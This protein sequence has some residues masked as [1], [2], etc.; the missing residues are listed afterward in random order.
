[1]QTIALLTVVFLPA[2]TVA[3]IFSMSPFFTAEPGG[4]MAV[5]AEFWIYWAVCI[6]LTLL[7]VLI[8]YLWFRRTRE[9]YRVEDKEMGDSQEGLISGSRKEE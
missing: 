9:R 1:M 5:S 8:W 4:R 6:P 2:T 7:V 3:A